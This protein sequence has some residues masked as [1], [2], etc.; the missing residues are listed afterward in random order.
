V[1]HS[2]QLLRMLVVDDEE[3][4][5]RMLKRLFQRRQS[6]SK[7]LAQLNK[8]SGELFG[9]PIVDSTEKN[10]TK[11]E[12][13]FRFQAEEAVDAYQE[14]MEN[15]QAFDLV[16]LDMRMPPG[17]DGIW[18]AQQ[19]RRFDQQVP[20]LLVTA[21]SN[22]KQREV[23]EQVQPS[24]RILVIHKPFAMLEIEKQIADFWTQ[25]CTD[26]TTPSQ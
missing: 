19:I 21:F 15:G 12:L 14:S 10:E 3:V 16:M 5:H 26:E 17:R 24:D 9:E 18:A 22:L 20:L 6:I 23:G 1:K 8:L 2:S 7:N 11:F 4:N 13:T 25:C